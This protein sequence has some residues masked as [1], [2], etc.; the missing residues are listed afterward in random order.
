MK[1]DYDATKIKV[2]EGLE[3]VRVR[4]GMYIGDT[5]QRGFH[6]CVFEIV[7]NAVD[8]AL[9]GFCSEIKVH[10]EENGSITVEDDGRGIPVDV[11][12]KEGM[13]A[14]ELVYT[15]L[16]AG[17]K[18]NEEDGAYKVS[19]GLH[20]VGAS[21]VN[22]LSSRLSVQ[23]SRNGKLYEIIFEQG[24]TVQKLKE[25]GTSSKNGTKVNFILDH[26]IFEVS[27]FSYNILAN[28]FR[29]MA[30]LNKKLKIILEDRREEEVKEEVF[31]FER[32]IAQFV[33]YLT[34]GK[35][36]L[37]Q[38]PI[39]F[40]AEREGS[41]IEVALQWNSS[42][43]EQ[44]SSFANNINTPE[45]G[46]HLSGFKSALTRVVN[47]YAKEVPSMKGISLTGEDLREGLV[48]VV[49]VK[50][51]HPQFEGQTKSKLGN[52]EIEGFVA[53]YVGEKLKTFLEEN[54]DVAQIIL[55]K[56]KEA[57]LAREAARK[58]RELTRKKS[59][60]ELSG[61]PGKMADCQERDPALCEIYIVE[62]DSA[63]GSAKQARDRRVQAVLPLRG[64]ILNVEK[65][66]F[67]KMISNEEIQ[68]LTKALG[69]SLVKDGFKEEDLKFHKVIIMTDA[70]V[71][72]SHI[73]TLLLTFFF[74][75]FQPLVEKG[76]VYIA[77]PPLFKYKKGKKER[78]LKDQKELEIFLLKEHLESSSL[79]VNNSKKN[80]EETLKIFKDFQH[81]K[82]VAD[83]FFKKHLVSLTKYF[84]K[85][86]IFH[87][88]TLLEE[89]LKKNFEEEF[90]LHQDFVKTLELYKPFSKNQK[91]S[92]NE[93]SYEGFEE[94]YRDFLQESKKGAYIQRYK[95]LG[96][97]N[98]EQLWET[99]MNPENR[100]LVKVTVEDGVEADRIFSVLMG[101]DVIPR[102]E[103]IEQN[104]LRV[105]NLDI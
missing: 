43:L 23:V 7:D 40:E 64:K 59:A 53:S 67:D 87:F 30:F 92:F 35:T 65:A 85:F 6:H 84:Q 70:D 36:P 29:E 14:V 81:Y 3:A 68:N 31:Y 76:F 89:F 19:G 22:A 5:G 58:A 101:D 38:K 63:G 83:L 54:P 95:G 69:T 9:A 44:I 77:Q 61:L 98:P 86:G 50:L 49:S 72:G 52:S 51:T 25:I 91:F 75:Q 94:L 99:T 1:K 2:L 21:V 11:H 88:E 18:F 27:K 93:K 48:A 47:Q 97:M 96:E 45:G 103:F 57:A 12:E 13:P 79:S 82:D 73:R 33:E 10:I 46:T 15:K 80:E 26:S 56:A 60:L 8:E 24:K 78:Y 17:G 90:F 102:R 37:H 104:A 66:R 16:H 100:T 105:K 39:F 34:E 4:P 41:S 32:G 42:Y 55:K 20:G 71:D 28:R 62:G 74:R